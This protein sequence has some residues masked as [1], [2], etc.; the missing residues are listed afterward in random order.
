MVVSSVVAR[1]EVVPAAMDLLLFSKPFLVF[2]LGCSI[3]GTDLA[4][5]RRLTILLTLMS[6]VILFAL[7]FLVFPTLHDNYLGTLRVADVRMGLRSASG[8]FDGPG[9]YSWFCATTF[10]ISYAA[11][12]AFERRTFAFVSLLSA[13]FVFLS[14]RRKS[15]GGVIAMVLIAVLLR[16]GRDGRTR[17]RAVLTLA[18][19][20]LVGVTALAPIVGSLWDITVRE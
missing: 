6:G 15:I 8:F 17:R 3:A 2:A 11:Y 20:A 5:P 13:A 14:W 7:V 9:P 18:V 10:A 4:T 12:L 16:T 1:V 19:V